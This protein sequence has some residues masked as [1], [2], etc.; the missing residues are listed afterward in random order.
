MFSC[1]L[2]IVSMGHVMLS[3]VPFPNNKTILAHQSKPSD[4]WCVR[5]IYFPL[6]HHWKKFVTHIPLTL[7]N[8]PSY[9]LL[10]YRKCSTLYLVSSLPFVYALC[11]CLSLSSQL[12]QWKRYRFCPKRSI[13][14]NHN[15]KFGECVAYFTRVGILKGE[16]YY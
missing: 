13:Q 12:K 7:R 6:M 14:P 2:V 9:T 3:W 4:E 5:Y 8:P 16:T 10:S 1:D 15:A 11:V